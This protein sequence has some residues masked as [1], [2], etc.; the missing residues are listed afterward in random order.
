MPDPEEPLSGGNVNAVVRVGDTVRRT[1]GPWTPTIHALLAWVRAHGVDRVPAPLGLDAQGREVLG[2]VPG[3]VGGWSQD[4]W[5]WAPAVLDDAARVLRAWHDATAAFPR[6]GM[7]WRMAAHEPAEVICLNDCAPYNMVG[8]PDGLVGFIDVDMA[9]PGPRVWD[10]AYLAYR[11]CPFAEDAAPPSGV[12]PHARL[13][14]LLSAYDATPSDGAHP[15]ARPV[16][17]DRAAVLAAIPARLVELAEYTDAHAASTGRAD[18]LDHAAMYRRDA[19]R[20][21]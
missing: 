20:L 19:A 15:T 7:R 12:D 10:L 2:Y 4:D 21:A 16:T 13:A 1:A 9:S 8:G 11:L 18:L 3:V 17:T 14:A 6:D 5:T